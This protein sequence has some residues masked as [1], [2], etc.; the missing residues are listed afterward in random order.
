MSNKKSIVVIFY[1]PTTFFYFNRWEFYQVEYEQLK[2]CCKEVIPVH[3]LWGFLKEILRKKVD[4]IYCYWWHTSAP[5]V[6]LSYIFKIKCYVT[7]AV[8]MYDESGAPDFFKKNFFYRLLNRISW[9]YAYRNFFISKS[10]MRQI[11]S[12]EY[13]RNGILFK[14]TLRPNYNPENINLDRWKT[15]KDE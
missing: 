8:H 14:S 11:T 7:G 9:R 10:Q 3:S 5:I 1:A 15:Q 2:S 12:H 6:L 13:V 4:L